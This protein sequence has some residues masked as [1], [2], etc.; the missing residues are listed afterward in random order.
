[1]PKPPS[2]PVPKTSLKVQTTSPSNNPNPK[3]R[4]EDDEVKPPKD[5]PDIHK[6][7]SD[8][9]EK[10]PAPTAEKKPSEAPGASG[11]A[12]SLS[13]TMRQA[14]ERLANRATVVGYLYEATGAKSAVSSAGKAVVSV[15]SRTPK[16]PVDSAKKKDN[17]D[18]SGKNEKKASDPS[19]DPKNQSRP[20][21]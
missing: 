4:P 20:K 8:E 2:E 11:S 12:E 16:D 21:T 19:S 5:S 17:S 1:M 18:P 15:F 13:V 9:S 14:F 7:E 10:K 6:V 3:P